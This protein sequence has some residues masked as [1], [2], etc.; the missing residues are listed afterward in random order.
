VVEKVTGDIG[1]MKTMS[2]YMQEINSEEGLSEES[3]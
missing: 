3:K 2:S 1:F